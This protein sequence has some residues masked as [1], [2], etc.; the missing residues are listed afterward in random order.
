VTNLITVIALNNWAIDLIQVL[1]ALGLH[2][3]ELL[4]VGTLRDATVDR[5]TSILQTLGILL[6]CDWPAILFLWTSRLVG[7]APS[8]GVFLVKVTLEVH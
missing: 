1:R 6:G 4:A 5:F 8:D 3:T 7:P 2:M